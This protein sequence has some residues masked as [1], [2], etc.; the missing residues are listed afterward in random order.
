MPYFSHNAMPTQMSNGTLVVWHVG[1]GV[2]RA[3]FIAGCTDGVTPVMPS[4]SPAPK[5]P[6]LPSWFPLP[7][8]QDTGGGNWTWQTTNVTTVHPP[9]D[10]F[11]IGNLASHEFS[12]GT[13]LLSYTVRPFSYLPNATT[14]AR[15]FGLAVADSWRGRRVKASEKLPSSMV[16][17]AVLAM[18][19]FFYARDTRASV[20]RARTLRTNLY[21][22]T[23]YIEYTASSMHL[24]C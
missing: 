11:H 22:C 5:A 7:F 20:P 16:D 24:A 17:A 4:P 18:F 21:M 19:N 15:G 8:T 13:V 6:T 3:P 23:R 1:R 14:H 12:N 9:N 2:P 10:E